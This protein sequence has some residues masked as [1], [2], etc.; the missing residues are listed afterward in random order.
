MKQG[1]IQSIALGYGEDS[2][3]RSGICADFLHGSAI[4]REMAQMNRTT[5]LC[6]KAVALLFRNKR[7]DQSGDTWMLRRQPRRAGGGDL[8]LQG[9]QKQHEVPDCKDMMLHEQ[10][11]LIK[12]FDPE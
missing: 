3:D 10:S 5:E 7:I 4:D 12:R 6:W 8:M 2:I 11:Q 1:V 9:L